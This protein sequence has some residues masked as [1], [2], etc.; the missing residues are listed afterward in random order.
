[1]IRALRQ[2]VLTWGALVLP[3][4]VS[5]HNGEVLLSRLTLHADG[6]C[7]LKVTADLEGNY[8]I[9]ERAEL[10]K[11][12]EGLFTVS[13]GKDSFA[14]KEATGEPQFSSATKLETDSPFQH[15]AEELAK[16][17]QLE[18]AEWRW[19]P[20]PRNFLLRLPDESPHTVLLWLVDETKPGAKARWVMMVAGDESPLIQAHEDTGHLGRRML[21]LCSG[22]MLIVAAALAF[23]FLM[24][25]RRLARPAA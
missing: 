12:V 2:L 24:L 22:T 7:S 10:A 9:R 6:T 25:R 20:D 13:T 14:L 8:N 3:L 4:F 5:A 23:G 21:I 18:S 17:Y 1:M 19:T 15:T 11:A 16:S